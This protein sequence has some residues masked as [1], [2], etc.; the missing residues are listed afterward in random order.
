MKGFT[1]I[2]VDP[3]DENQ[4]SDQYR[5]GQ[6][7]ARAVLGHDL[8]ETLQPGD[9]TLHVHGWFSPIRLRLQ[10]QSRNVNRIAK[11]RFP[12]KPV[13]ID[14]YRLLPYLLSWFWNHDVNQAVALECRFV[15]S[16][17]TI[18]VAGIVDNDRS[19]AAG[20]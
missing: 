19:A 8:T 14:K 20:Q 17:R 3:T 2:L 16:A 5:Q 12:Q 18:G 4:S 9:Y 10:R 1:Q 7:W 11:K 6:G 15:I 13:L